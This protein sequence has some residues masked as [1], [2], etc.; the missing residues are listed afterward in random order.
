MLPA[1]KDIQDEIQNLI[2]DSS[3][4]LKCKI[5]LQISINRWTFAVDFDDGEH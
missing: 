2:T 1:R 4:V 5:S 3:M